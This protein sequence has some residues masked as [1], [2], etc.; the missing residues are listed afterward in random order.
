M[1]NLNDRRLHFFTTLFVTGSAAMSGGCV[2]ESAFAREVRQTRLQV[3]AL[4]QRVGR[5]EAGVAGS[6][7]AV[8]SGALAVA[9]AGS[10]AAYATGST[11]AGSAGRAARGGF[12][13]PPIFSRNALGKLARGFVNTVTGWVEIPKR[14]HETTVTSG[15]GAGLTFGLLRGVGYGFVRTLA[16]VYEVVTFPFPAP[17]D[18]R[19]V[20]QPEYVFTSDTP[21]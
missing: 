4:E 15:V 3:E 11:V 20:M 10:D 2:F 5:L 8:Q 1:P 13:F 6:A 14:M 21:A 9:A 16:G 19:P 12:A 17:P 18:Y 7:G